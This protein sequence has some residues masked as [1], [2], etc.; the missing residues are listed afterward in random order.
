[1]RSSPVH[2]TLLLFAALLPHSVF[3]QDV[4]EVKPPPPDAAAFEAGIPHG[5]TSGN[6]ETGIFRSAAPFLFDLMVNRPS[7]PVDRKLTT[8]FREDGSIFDTP[9]NESRRQMA[10]IKVCG[11]V[12]YSPN[13]YWKGG[14]S[15]AHIHQDNKGDQKTFFP[16][17]NQA[18]A[19]VVAGKVARDKPLDILTDRTSS[20]CGAAPPGWSD[21]GNWGK[22]GDII[23]HYIARAL[24]PKDSC[25]VS[26]SHGGGNGLQCAL[27]C[28]PI[29]PLWLQ[30][31]DIYVRQKR[32][33]QGKTLYSVA[34]KLRGQ[35]N[36]GDGNG[37]LKNPAWLNAQCSGDD[38]YFK[39]T[40]ND[41]TYVVFY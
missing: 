17:L 26:P 1:M 18:T 29:S 4:D 41:P 2:S 6:N 35:F 25:A 24:A 21:N 15:G 8:I 23:D 27:P 12:F 40:P 37:G 10:V 34:Y 14:F 19:D 22:L 28:D 32:S 33:D 9:D 16:A 5:D 7:W 11:G 38:L 36:R 31:T 3:G 30:S 20:A 13:M 39:E